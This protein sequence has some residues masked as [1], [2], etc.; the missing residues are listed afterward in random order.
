M[1]Y[2]YHPAVLDELLAHGIRPTP[3]TPPSRARELLN[4]LYRYELRELRDRLRR[5]EFPKPTYAARV[6][7]LRERYPL[8]SIPMDQWAETERT[9]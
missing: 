1:N 9:P 2:R 6:V 5:R 4:D 7:A 8:L 3:A